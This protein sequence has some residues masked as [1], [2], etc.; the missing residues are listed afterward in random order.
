[1][2]NRKSK[3]EENTLYRTAFHDNKEI[4]KKQIKKEKKKKKDKTC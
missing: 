4:E 2:E 1:M 3:K